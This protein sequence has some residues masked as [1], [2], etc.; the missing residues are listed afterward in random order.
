MDIKENSLNPNIV[1]LGVDEVNEAFRVREDF[2][3]INTTAC[4]RRDCSL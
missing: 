2:K 3:G 4:C 1:L